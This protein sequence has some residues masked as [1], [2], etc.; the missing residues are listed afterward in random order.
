MWRVDAGWTERYDEA[1][2]HQ[3][4]PGSVLVGTTTHDYGYDDLT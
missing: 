3:G 4:M 2:Y 1:P